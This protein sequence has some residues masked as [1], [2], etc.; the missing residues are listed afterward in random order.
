[1]ADTDT[2]PRSADLV[3]H[4]VSDAIVAYLAEQGEIVND[5]F[6]E[7]ATR[8]RWMSLCRSLAVYPRGQ[9]SITVRVAGPDVGLWGD[10]VT[11]AVIDRAT[12]NGPDGRIGEFDAQTGRVAFT[13]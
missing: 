13:W 10:L 11:A 3:A 8:N 7:Q 4:D 9:R 5:V 2:A 1:M 12:V 6:C